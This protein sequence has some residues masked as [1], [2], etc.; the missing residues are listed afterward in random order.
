[1][2]AI[3]IIDDRADIRRTLKRSVDTVLPDINKLASSAWETMPSDPLDKLSDYPDWISR[4]NIAALIVDQKLQEQVRNH[5]GYNGHNLVSFLKDKA[6]YNSLPIFIVTGF[7][8]DDSLKR[9]KEEKKVERIIRRGDF[10]RN[11]DTLVP[12]LISA[13]HEYLKSI[14]ITVNRVHDDIIE[15]TTDAEAIQFNDDDTEKI[16]CLDLDKFTDR[17][18][19]VLGF[20]KVLSLVENVFNTNHEPEPRIVPCIIV[21]GTPPT[22][23]YTSGAN[24]E[25]IQWL[26]NI[27]R[28]IYGGAIF[29]QKENKDESYVR[30]VERIKGIPVDLKLKPDESQEQPNSESTKKPRRL[31]KDLAAYRDPPVPVSQEEFNRLLKRLKMREKDRKRD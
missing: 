8:I 3:G 12:E 30:I 6:R 5:V 10:S 29:Y 1:M 9:I 2:P 21:I 22:L 31:S 16:I 20:R 26:E 28:V 18:G 27:D 25:K 17:F 15:V 14:P 23:T 19:E 7:E 13:G 4:H 11:A 24:E